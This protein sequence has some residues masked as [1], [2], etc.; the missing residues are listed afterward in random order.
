[1]KYIIF[2]SIMI[3]SNPIYSNEEDYK[4]YIATNKEGKS[5]IGKCYSKGVFRGISQV[6]RVT[7]YRDG[8]IKVYKYKE[9]ANELYLV[10]DISYRDQDGNRIWEFSGVE[11]IKYNDF[12]SSFR[13]VV[14]PL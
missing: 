14:C 2:L 4:P 13:P 12:T 1:M 6:S 11:K 8:I 7:S 9:K 5:F 10:Q 3:L